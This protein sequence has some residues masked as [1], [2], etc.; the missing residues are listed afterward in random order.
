MDKTRFH[1]IWNE[2]I[3]LQRR[4][5]ERETAK[6]RELEAEGLPK[7]TSDCYAVA[8]MWDGTADVSGRLVDVDFTNWRLLLRV[9]ERAFIIVDVEELRRSP[10]TRPLALTLAQ[11]FATRKI[12]QVGVGRLQIF[13]NGDVAVHGTPTGWKS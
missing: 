12:P 1:E 13:P 2:L 4:I 8:S 9:S 5:I 3:P 10:E 11:R 7:T 6:L